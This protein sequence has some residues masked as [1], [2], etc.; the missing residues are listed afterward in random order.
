M[1]IDTRIRWQAFV[2]EFS[3]NKTGANPWDAGL[4][5]ANSAGASHGERLT[6][7]FLLNVWDGTTEWKVGK[8]DCIEAIATWSQEQRAAFADWARNPWWP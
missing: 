2:D 5:D 4:L 6:I 1:D 8:F 7:S 3:L